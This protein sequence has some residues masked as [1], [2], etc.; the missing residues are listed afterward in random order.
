MYYLAN[1]KHLKSGQKVA[2]LPKN[3]GYMLLASPFYES[4]FSLFECDIKES[5]KFPNIEKVPKENFFLIESAK[6]YPP[7]LAI[8]RDNIQ[9]QFKSHPT[10]KEF[11]DTYC[12]VLESLLSQQRDSKYFI[13]KA[14]KTE[15]GYL[16]KGEYYWIIDYK[17]SGEVSWVSR[18]YFV[19]Q[20][21]LEYFDVEEEY[22]IN[23]FKL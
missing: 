17:K 14:S 18:D 4:E 22:L 23:R 15:S 13:C 6:Q 2:D 8:G 3:I 21:C 9:D 20:N 16:Y 7:A 1:W 19:Y 10:R 12:Q 11:L 5:D